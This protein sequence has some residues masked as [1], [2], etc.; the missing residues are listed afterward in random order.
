MVRYTRITRWT[1]NASGVI[2]GIPTKLIPCQDYVL[3]ASNPSG[4]SQFMM[5]ICVIDESPY[6]LSYPSTLN[7]FTVNTSISPLI[8]IVQG[9]DVT[10]F[11]ADPP[12]AR[13]I[14]IT[15][16]NHRYHNWSIISHPLQQHAFRSGLTIAVA[17]LQL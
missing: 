7:I 17:A 2:T 3:N 9:G 1:L 4:Y 6:G 13:G 8:P 14:V 15:K 10:M 11:I 12:A 5:T 16:R